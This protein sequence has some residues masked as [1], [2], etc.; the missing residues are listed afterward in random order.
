MIEGWRRC[1]LRTKSEPR[2]RQDLPTINISMN[3][4]ILQ[5]QS[6]RFMRNARTRPRR[7]KPYTCIC[8]DNVAIPWLNSILRC[9]ITECNPLCM[10]FSSPTHI[11]LAPLLLLHGI[12]RQ[13]NPILFSVAHNPH[14][15]YHPPTTQRTQ[16]PAPAHPQV[17]P[18]L[19]PAPPPH[20]AQKSANYSRACSYS[21]GSAIATVVKTN[22]TVE[23]SPQYCVR[24]RF[25][26][27]RRVRC[28]CWFTNSRERYHGYSPGGGVVLLLQ[29][30]ETVTIW[31]TG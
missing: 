10:V 15:Y 5:P 23:L 26:F 29:L 31:S 18:Q 6:L 28:S 21:R 19:L 20:P 11:S 8:T 17:P 22:S 3:F 1:C 25:S 16:Q 9:R 7:Q 4:P 24:Y 12:A 13:Q 30:V 2:M 14:Y 27:R